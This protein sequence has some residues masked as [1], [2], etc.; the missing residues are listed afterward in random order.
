M[1]NTIR[2]NVMPAP[3]HGQIFCSLYI[4]ERVTYDEL[5]DS[6][7]SPWVRCLADGSAGEIWWNWYPPAHVARQAG[8]CYNCWPSVRRMQDG[9]YMAIVCYG[10]GRGYYQRGYPTAVAAWSALADNLDAGEPL[11]EYGHMDD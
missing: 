5:Y 10:Y 2:P 11:W 1:Q 4:H 3:C 7:A 6:T 9:T 8:A